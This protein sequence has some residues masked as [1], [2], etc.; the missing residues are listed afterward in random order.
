MRAPRSVQTA[1]ALAWPRDDGRPALGRAPEHETLS[2]RRAVHDINTPTLLGPNR[3]PTLRGTSRARNFYEAMLPHAG[4]GVYANFLVNQGPERVGLPS[5]EVRAARQG[6]AQ[7]QPHELLSISI[8]TS[9]LRRPTSA[10][11]GAPIQTR[12]RRGRR[13]SI[14]QDA[15]LPSAEGCIRVGDRFR[16]S[17]GAARASAMATLRSSAIPTGRS[18]SP[19]PPSPLSGTRF[20]RPQ[21]SPF[22]SDRRCCPNGEDSPFHGRR[23]SSNKA[24]L[25]NTGRRRTQ[26]TAHAAAPCSWRTAGPGNAPGWEPW[27]EVNDCIQAAPPSRPCALGRQ[28]RDSPTRQRREPRSRRLLP[29]GSGSPRV[30]WRLHSRSSKEG[31]VCGLASQMAASDRAKTLPCREALPRWLTRGA[32]ARSSSYGAVPLSPVSS[33]A[34]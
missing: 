33:W 1:R 9:S 27:C 30:C 14:R 8:K 32:R 11:A 34:G 20:A 6:Q 12:I 31:L 22:R 17:G 29:S 21:P 10:I 25:A 16:I 19:L 26:R 3:T 24:N 2:Q 28:C 4:D 18:A 7:P 23:A 5:T 15:N 13:L